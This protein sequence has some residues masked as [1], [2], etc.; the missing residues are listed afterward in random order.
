M[1]VESPKLTVTSDAE[2]PSV[3]EPDVATPNA[4]ARSMAEPDVAAPNA[5]AP[6]VA[7]DD[8][9]SH[10][11]WG[12]HVYKPK[13][14]TSAEYARNALGH[15]KTVAHHKALV[16]DLARRAG[17]AGQGVVH[18]LSKLSPTEFL[19]GVEYFQGDRSPNAAERHD[20]GCS[21][22]WMHHK[23]NNR[24]HY[25]YW[26]DMRDGGDGTLYGV[27][28]PTRYLVEMMCDRIAACKVYKKNAYTDS[29][30]LEYF[31]SELAVGN[32]PMHPDSAAFLYTLLSLVA[33]MG[34]DDALRYV[35]EVIVKPRFVYSQNGRF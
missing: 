14:S 20:K 24:H 16:F 19:V 22:A 23:G 6:S 26:T 8:A 7:S 30:P 5:E 2:A 9:E 10:R 21:E 1:S 27:P 31:Q 25:E 33:Q 32:L 35:R 17:I 3:A 29:A 13:P 4:E 18:D 34:E 11:N 12:N 28:M 15:L